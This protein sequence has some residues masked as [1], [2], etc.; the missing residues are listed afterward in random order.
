MISQR[1]FSQIGRACLTNRKVPIAA[2]KATPIVYHSAMLNVC[3]FHHRTTEKAEE[4]AE[5]QEK[6]AKQRREQETTYL[7]IDL[8][9]A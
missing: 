6:R 8:V 7:I 5:R 1:G 2:N 3:R 4:K 9:Q